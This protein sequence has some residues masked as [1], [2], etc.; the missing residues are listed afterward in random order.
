MKSILRVL[1]ISFAVLLCI[2]GMARIASTIKQDSLRE[3]DLNYLTQ[4]S[5]R[6]P[7]EQLE[8]PYNRIA[9][10]ATKYGLVEEGDVFKKNK[11]R[12]IIMGDSWL[13]SFKRDQLKSFAVHLQARFPDIDILSMAHN[14]YSSY[15]G[16]KL[17]PLV[18]DLKPSL[19]IV[20]YSNNDRRCVASKDDMDSDW[21]FKRVVVMH[22]LNRYLYVLHGLDKIKKNIYPHPTQDVKISELYPRVSKEGYYENMSQIA[23]ELK[24]RGIPVIFLRYIKNPAKKKI[25]EEG[26]TYFKNSQYE[27]AIKN[28]NSLTE[29]YIYRV[30]ARI[31]LAR[32]YEKMGLKEEAAK[33]LSFKIPYDNDIFGYTAPIYLDKEYNDIMKKVADQYGVEFLDPGRLEDETLFKDRAHFNEE[34]HKRLADFLTPYIAKYFKEK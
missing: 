24:K 22:N 32:V 21:R 20:C 10:S 27:S 29:D 1:I 9:Y 7:A 12:I 34:G 4:D 14:G 23:R 2:E 18:I 25:F 33:Q 5:N 6:K 17:L 28:F 31:Y 26:I 3:A 15:Q 13:V 11:P 19:V 16:C 30:L 8:R